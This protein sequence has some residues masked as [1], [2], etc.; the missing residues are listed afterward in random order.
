VSGYSPT[1]AGTSGRDGYRPYHFG[2]IYL[3]EHAAKMAAEDPELTVM[4]LLR[5]DPSLVLVRHRQQRWL[6]GYNPENGRVTE[7]PV[8]PALAAATAD[9]SSSAAEPAE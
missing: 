8:P 3:H 2:G 1:Q 9:D 4:E 5:N 6:F 7:L